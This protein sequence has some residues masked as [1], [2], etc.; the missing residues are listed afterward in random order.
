MCRRLF[1]AACGGVVV[2]SAATAHARITLDFD[3]G[4][5]VNG[6]FSTSTANGQAA[7]AALLYA[8]DAYSDR[9]LDTF[10]AISPDGTTNRWQPQVFNPADGTVLTLSNVSVAANAIKIYAGGYD[11]PDNTLGLGGRGGYIETYG[12][13]SFLNAV[14]TRGQAGA[15]ASPATDYGPWGGSIRFDT[16]VNWNFSIA[17]APTSNS[18]N[19]FLSVALHELGHMM[20]VGSAASFTALS[21]T[22]NGNFVFTGT[23]STALYGANVPLANAGHVTAVTSS[24]TGNETQVVAMSPSLTTGTRKLLTKLDWALFDD[25]GWD[26]ARPGDANASGSVNFDDLLVIAA[27]FNGT[28]KTWSEGDFNYDRTTNFNDLLALAA[29]F[30]TTGPLGAA[31]MAQL[32]DANADFA[33]EWALAQSVV[34]EPTTLLA[35]AAGLGAVASRPRR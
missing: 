11:L 23:K 35:A 17:N 13:S 25:L 5:D 34:P 16:L 9:F 15:G 4:Y 26:L 33:A 7:R 18:Q 28:G 32:N 19:D 14:S 29:N 21:Q 12:T 1:A 3:F 2:L 22:V 10:S 27:N 24:V 20:G 30:N 6:F 31:Q 8:A